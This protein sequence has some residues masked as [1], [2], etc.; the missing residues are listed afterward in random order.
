MT[1]KL[2]VRGPVGVNELTT[3]KYKIYGE[4]Q[5]KLN[6]KGN[7]GYSGLLA[8]IIVGSIL[9]FIPLSLIMLPLGYLASTYHIP[10]SIVIL[11]A[12]ILFF[13]KEKPK[14]ETMTKIFLK[15]PK[16]SNMIDNQIR[17]LQ[18]F[19]SLPSTLSKIP[20]RG[21]LLFRLLNVSFWV[22]CF[23]SLGYILTFN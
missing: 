13:F 22:T 7:F 16:F 5:V 18:Q 1:S 17:G 4:G 15:Y 3:Y 23:S 12:T 11:I 6:W 21:L 10:L 9:S 20:K 14:F 2:H 8:I 19:S